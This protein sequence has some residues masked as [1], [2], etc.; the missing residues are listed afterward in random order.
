MNS[1]THRLITRRYILSNIS[2]RFNSNT[3][4]PIQ[5]NIV[6]DNVVKNNIAKD[7][8]VKSNEKTTSNVSGIRA[9]LAICTV[10]NV[11]I[12]WDTVRVNNAHREATMELE[13]LM[14]KCELLLRSNYR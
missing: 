10:A 3:T 12:I 9:L 4:N 6:K 13:V 11:W 7:N 2:K 5:N 14:A 8:V 1:L